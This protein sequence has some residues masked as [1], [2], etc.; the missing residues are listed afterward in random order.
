MGLIAWSEPWIRLVVDVAAGITAGLVFNLL[1][2]FDKGDTDS[3]SHTAP[4]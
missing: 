3:T 2:P 1:N 4:E